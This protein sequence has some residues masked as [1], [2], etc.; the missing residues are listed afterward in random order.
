MEKSYLLKIREIQSVTGP[1]M[2][3]GSSK[4]LAL[5]LLG[6]VDPTKTLYDF[7]SSS[8]AHKHRRLPLANYWGSDMSVYNND[9]NQIALPAAVN[10]PSAGVKASGIGQIRFRTGFT[11]DSNTG[12]ADTMLTQR[13]PLVV[14]VSIHGGRSRDHFIVIF[15]DLLARNWA[16]DP[17]PGNSDDAVVELDKDMTFT[18]PTKVHLTADAKVTEIPCGAPFFGHFA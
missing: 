3:L 15:K 1:N 9:F 17:W 11:F 18:K 5:K 2:C 4:F 6:L 8:W 13:T 12:T 14:G 16:I 7:L 10:N